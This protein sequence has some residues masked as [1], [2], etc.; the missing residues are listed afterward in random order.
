MKVLSAELNPGVQLQL[1]E[2]LATR[3][4]AVWGAGQQELADES[5][6]GSLET[7]PGTTHDLHDEKP[8]VVADALEA[9]LQEVSSS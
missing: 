3:I 1:P 2:E 7:V 8:Q 4:D 5:T 9:I 6:A